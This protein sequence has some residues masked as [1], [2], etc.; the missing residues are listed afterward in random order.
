MKKFEWME[1][2]IAGGEIDGVVDAIQKLDGTILQL[3]NR[4]VLDLDDE[5]IVGLYYI[6]LS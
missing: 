6:D 5:M 4:A 1:A 3:A 2:V